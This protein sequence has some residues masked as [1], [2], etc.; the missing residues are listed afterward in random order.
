MREAQQMCCVEEDSGSPQG[1]AADGVAEGPLEETLSN[2]WVEPTLA[3]R[4]TLPYDR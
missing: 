2:K 1:K 3:T 4:T